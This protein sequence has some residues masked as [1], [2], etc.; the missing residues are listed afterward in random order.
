VLPPLLLLLFLG[1][2]VGVR[3]AAAKV[4]LA[5]HERLQFAVRELEYELHRETPTT[6]AVIEEVARRASEVES[7]V[8]AA[9]LSNEV[10]QPLLAAVTG[11]RR[12]VGRSLVRWT[13]ETTLVELRGAWEAIRNACFTPPAA[14]GPTDTLDA[15]QRRRDPAADNDL[16]ARL[17]FMEKQYEELLDFAADLRGRPDL[18]DT[19]YF[20]TETSRWTR[21]IGEEVTRPVLRLSK[22]APSDVRS[23]WT[24]LDLARTRLL[25]WLTW[26]WSNYLLRDSEREIPYELEKIRRTRAKIEATYFP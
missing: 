1:A 5:E 3:A 15:I 23:A 10:K 26:P 16:L 6:P 13:G 20:S 18:E 11:Y 24:E 21:R 7:A 17:A 14:P 8:L 9:G 19:T 12:R 4:P 22:R 25:G 2:D